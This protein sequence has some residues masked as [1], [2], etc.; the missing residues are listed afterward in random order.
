MGP[1]SSPSQR[2]SRVGTNVGHGSL[3][4]DLPTPARQLQRRQGPLKTDD[5]HDAAIHST[6]I[7]VVLREGLHWP[8][9]AL[10][11][12]GK[13]L[14]F[15]GIVRPPGGLRT[16][17]IGVRAPSSYPAAGHRWIRRQACTALNAARDSRV[18]VGTRPLIECWPEVYQDTRSAIFRGTKR[19]RNA[20]GRDGQ[21][22]PVHGSHD[23]PLLA[24]LVRS[25]I[26][27]VEVVRDV[28]GS[29]LT[30]RNTPS[31]HA[32]FEAPTGDIGRRQNNPLSN[33]K[34]DVIVNE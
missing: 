28:D 27:R 5:L 15:V 17:S 13:L 20:A 30:C 4:A 6:N 3:V 8:P 25:W 26:P 10:F 11:G 19:R 7:A 29:G 31:L 24:R 2:A 12:A 9:A 21:P 33:V 34:R 23:L 22:E 32:A 14:A 16:S 18:S 1:L